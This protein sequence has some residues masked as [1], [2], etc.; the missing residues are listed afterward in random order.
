M[1]MWGNNHKLYD[2]DENGVDEYGVDHSK[3]TLRQELEYNMQKS[4]EKEKLKELGNKGYPILRNDKKNFFNSTIENIVQVI[5]KNILSNNKFSQSLGAMRDLGEN[6]INMVNANLKSSDEM[7]SAGTTID[8][9]YHCIGNYDATKRGAFGRNMARMIGN[10]REDFDYL[11]N[12]LIKNKTEKDAYSDK[13]N[14]LIINNNARYMAGNG[15][16]NSAQEACEKY[17]P[18][19]YDY[20]ERLKYYKK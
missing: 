2:I 7:K 19:Q 6:Y 4:A 1:D 20:N 10:V 17:R 14:D 3:F 8:N 18:T 5:P 11:N 12:K 16:Y 15:L 13:I 9:Y